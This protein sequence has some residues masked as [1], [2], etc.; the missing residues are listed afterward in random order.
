[1]CAVLPNYLS[2][3]GCEA[4]ELLHVSNGDVDLMSHVVSSSW[5]IQR[6]V[7]V[8][9]LPVSIR[10]PLYYTSTLMPNFV[11]TTSHPALHS[12]TTEIR[13]LFSRPEMM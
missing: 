9:F 4:L 13:E 12:F 1:M 7:L 2:P 6:T 5:T 11:N 3:I 10:R 8:H